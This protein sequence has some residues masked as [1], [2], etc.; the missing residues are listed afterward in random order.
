MRYKKY[1]AAAE[2]VSKSQTAKC[3][4]DAAIALFLEKGYKNVTTRDIAARSDVNLG[5]IPYY[6]SSKVNLAKQACLQVLEGIYQKQVEQYDF[7]SLSNAEWM[8]ASSVLMWDTLDADPAVSRFYYEFV[9]TTDILTYTSSFISCSRNVIEHYNLKVSEEE[10]SLY[11][12]VMKAAERTLVIRHYKQE[13]SITQD[14]IVEILTS[15]YFFNIGL[16]DREIARIITAG[17]AYCQKQRH[18]Q[19]ME[20]R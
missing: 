4:L 20:N 3:I 12:I 6:Y 11:L 18:H 7:S 9:E 8:Y 5:L 2:P 16:P 17:R 19:K 10:N 15:N 14:D 1:I 13:L